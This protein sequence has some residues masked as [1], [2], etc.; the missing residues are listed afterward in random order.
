MSDF[1]IALQQIL[2]ALDTGNRTKAAG[3]G[4]MWK[5][6]QVQRLRRNGRRP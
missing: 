3:C 1:D 4:N 2:E 6:L 5:S